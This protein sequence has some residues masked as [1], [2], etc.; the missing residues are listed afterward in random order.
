MQTLAAGAKCVTISHRT[1]PADL[2]YPEGI[3]VRP[4]LEKI[5]GNTVRLGKTQLIVIP[6]I[7]FCTFGKRLTMP[8]SVPKK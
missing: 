3:E 1:T 5:D 8:N 4:L 2:A 6:V 7:P